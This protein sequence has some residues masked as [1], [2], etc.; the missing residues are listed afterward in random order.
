MNAEVI[1]GI[2]SSS[3]SSMGQWTQRGERLPSLSFY[4][5][6]LFIEKDLGMEGAQR[7]S[8]QENE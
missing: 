5:K 3:V 7:M 4:P 1:I 8:V 6:Y 2:A